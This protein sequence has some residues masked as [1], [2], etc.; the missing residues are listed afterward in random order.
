MKPIIT[1]AVPCYNSAAYMDHCIESILACGTTDIEII[2]VDDGSSDETPAKADAWLERYPDTIKVV[3]QENG[4]HGAAV[5]AGI[6]HASGTYFKVV[7]SDDWLDK[8]ANHAVL[9]TLR[10]FSEE[11][12]DL[13][14]VNYV[15]EHTADGTQEFVRYHSALPT[16]KVFGWDEVG[17]F[18][19]SQYILMHSV[20]YRTEVLRGCGLE[21]PR[22]TFYV[23]NIFAYVPLPSCERIYYLDVDLYRY[24]IGRDDQS[25]NEKVMIG[26]I[27]QQLRITRIMIDA[28]HL[29]EDVGSERLRAYML[30]YLG[31]M[32]T[33]CSVFAM[34][35]D[36]DDR[37]ELR[38]GIWAHLEEHDPYAY[39]KIRR[40]FLGIGA[41]LPGKLGD[42]IM[43][44]GY[45]LAQKLF[46]FN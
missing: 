5:M 39:K 22:H 42:R 15:Y 6:E 9:D 16:G 13:L 21:L 24:F 25:V 37:E 45:H 41:N 32:M 36:R 19:I 30:G 31:M 46:K 4:G 11:P 10:G 38:D 35:S 8:A 28:F 23:D 1:Y 40:G 14:I 12:I 26:R 27:D 18:N 3:H 34:L 7:D 33:I 43:I 17:H 44:G 20:I 2:I 29:R